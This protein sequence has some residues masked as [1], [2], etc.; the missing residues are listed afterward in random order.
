MGV[1]DLKHFCPLDAI[2]FEKLHPGLFFL[3]L[4]KNTIR[5]RNAT[6]V[7]LLFGRLQ[8]HHVAGAV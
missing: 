5:E 7:R 1:W 3:Q 4:P 2:L 8:S 6:L